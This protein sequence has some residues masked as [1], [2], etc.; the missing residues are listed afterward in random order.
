MEWTVE[1]EREAAGSKLKVSAGKI[2]KDILICL[3]GGSAPHIGCVVQAVPRPSL[4]GDGSISATASVLNLIG[5]KDEFLCRKLAELICSKTGC[6]TVCTGGFH[7]DGITGEQIQD[8]MKV[9]DE[10]GENLVERL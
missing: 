9:M 6:V 1:L 7:L 3:E 5:H 4:T 2:G 10:V 8:V